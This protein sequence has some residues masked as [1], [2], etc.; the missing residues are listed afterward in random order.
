MA[1]IACSTLI[2]FLLAGLVSAMP[3]KDPLLEPTLKPAEIR[4]L[5]TKAKKWIEAELKWD[6]NPRMRKQRDKARAKFMTELEK[7]SKSRDVLKSVG[8]MLQIFEYCFPYK[9]QSTYGE[10]K[11]YKAPPHHLLAPKG[12]KQGQ[13]YASV[14]AMPA[15]D[16]A[17]KGWLKPKPYINDTWKASEG[18]ASTFIVV[19]TL[20]PTGD[21]ST[22]NTVDSDQGR[23]DESARIRSVLSVFGEVQR[24]FRLDRERMFLDCGKGTSG[25]GVRLVTYFPSRFSGLIMRD[26][27]EIG[28]LQLQSLAGIPVLLISTDATKANCEAIKTALDKQ[29]EGSVTIIEGDSSPFKSSTA[30]IDKWMKGRSRR[31]FPKEVFIAPNHDAFHKAFWVEIISCEPLDAVKAEN[32]PYVKAS[33]DREKNRVVIET[34]STS[35]V[36]IYLNDVLVD[37]DKEV[38]FV[39]N[40]KE[41]TG[42]KFQRS[43]RTVERYLRR[44]YDTTSVYTAYHRIE[45]PKA[46]TKK[47]SD[48]DK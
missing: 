21:Y 2:L 26:P 8:D 4:S 45:I 28:E 32:R 18:A 11:Y 43:I 47:K 27:G 29:A 10:I 20:V 35:E 22:P 12:Y 36:G 46:D 44:A 23:L 42:T 37:L 1:R 38:T 25:F 7:K 39:V 41:I 17:S 5:N 33:A 16:E 24:T 40:G 14:L 34:K 15:W 30:A 3:Q 19:P 31:L 13:K 9:K 6:A 48:G